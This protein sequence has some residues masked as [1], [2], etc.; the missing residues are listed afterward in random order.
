MSRWRGRGVSL[1]QRIKAKIII[2]FGTAWGTQPG[3]RQVCA[4]EGFYRKNQ[5]LER[6]DMGWAWCITP[7]ILA[8]EEA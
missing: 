6:K 4:M 1:S 7:V 5:R 3:W 2:E 8:L